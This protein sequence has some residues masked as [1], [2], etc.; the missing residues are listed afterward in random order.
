MKNVKPS[1]ISNEISG[2]SKHKKSIVTIS[3]KRVQPQAVVLPLETFEAIR[4]LMDGLLYKKICPE[5]I[6]LE[7]IRNASTSIEENKYIDAFRVFQNAIGL[8]PRTIDMFDL[9]DDDLEAEL[10]DLGV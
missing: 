10:R 5:G 7:R 3:P 2:W 8:K 4:I 6:L 1:N 9:D